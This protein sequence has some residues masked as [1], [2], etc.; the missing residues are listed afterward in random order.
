MKRH[1]CYDMTGHEGEPVTKTEKDWFLVYLQEVDKAE[2][3]C[4][5]DWRD[6]MIRSG[7]LIIEEK[8]TE[9]K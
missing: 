4:F 3:K 2:Y 8:E 1:S 7:I 9:E 5:V 6:D